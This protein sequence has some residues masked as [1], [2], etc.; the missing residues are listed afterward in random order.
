MKPNNPYKKGSTIWAV[1][2]GDWEDLTARQIA[3]VLDVKYS[4]VRHYITRIRRQ[5]GYSVPHISE[6]E[7]RDGENEEY[8]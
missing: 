7:R 8:F 2:E 4:T 6:K 3:E 1:M 5:T